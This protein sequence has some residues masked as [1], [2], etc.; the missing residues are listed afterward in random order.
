MHI[1]PHRLSCKSAHAAWRLKL[2]ICGSHWVCKYTTCLGNSGFGEQLPK[3][4][5]QLKALSDGQARLTLDIAALK[6]NP[7]SASTSA[8]AVGP[9][10]AGQQM[11]SNGPAAMTDATAAASGA[12]AAQGPSAP[13]TA[14]SRAGAAVSAPDIRAAGSSPAADAGRFGQRLDALT[15]EVIP[16]PASARGWH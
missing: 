13:D 12:A 2:P 1:H 4:Q 8:A 15:D 10:Q 16:L 3:L 11:P 7:S 9:A 6:G 14:S 5:E